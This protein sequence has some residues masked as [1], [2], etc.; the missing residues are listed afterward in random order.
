MPLAGI[1]KYSVLLTVLQSRIQCS[2]L[3][4]TVGKNVLTDNTAIIVYNHI[5][6]VNELPAWAYSVQFAIFF[7]KSILT[8][9]EI[10]V[11]VST[12]EV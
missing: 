1:T 6:H 11:Y 7:D 5:A 3:V 8:V 2:Y 12:K 10:G 9:Y 4:S